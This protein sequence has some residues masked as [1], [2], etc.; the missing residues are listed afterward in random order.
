MNFDKTVTHSDGTLFKMFVRLS[1]SVLMVHLSRFF[2]SLDKVDKELEF[3]ATKKEGHL[4]PGD[5]LSSFGL[6]HCQCKKKIDAWCVY[7][8]V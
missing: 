1:T 5:N 6:Y 2:F 8:V 4:E 7:E 3:F